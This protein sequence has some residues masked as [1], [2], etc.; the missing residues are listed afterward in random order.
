MF[1]FQIAFHILN[2]VLDGLQRP[3]VILR[4]LVQL[5]QVHLQLFQVIN[6]KKQEYGD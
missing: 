4:N 6:T 3:I 5:E 2:S 1:L